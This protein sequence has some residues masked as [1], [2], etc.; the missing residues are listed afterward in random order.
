[1]DPYV[2][3]KKVLPGYA[4]SI[5]DKKKRNK[6]KLTKQA[7]GVF[8]ELILHFPDVLHLWFYPIPV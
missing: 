4:I 7:F 8:R 1:M 2:S 6:N 5:F 3:F